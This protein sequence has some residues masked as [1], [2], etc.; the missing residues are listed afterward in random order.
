M[1][2]TEKLDKEIRYHIY[3]VFTE[4]TRP[5]TTGDVAKFHNIDISQAEESYKRLANAHQIA[6]APGSFSIWMAHPFSSL[7]TNFTVDIGPNKY[8]AN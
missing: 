1:D 5:P 3:K 7:P 2:D 6:L 8:F 4:A